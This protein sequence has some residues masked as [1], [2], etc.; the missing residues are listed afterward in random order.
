MCQ[1]WLRSD[2]RDEQGGGGTD[3]Q[4]DRQGQLYIV[5]YRL[6]GFAREEGW[7]PREGGEWRE[8]GGGEVRVGGEGGRGGGGR[9]GREG[10]REGPSLPPSANIA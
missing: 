3:R 2:G 1:I 10:A 8:G 5:D 7:D 4:T 6:P 9:R